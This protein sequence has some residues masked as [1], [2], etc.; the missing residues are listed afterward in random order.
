MLFIIIIIALDVC[1]HVKFRCP[2]Q[3]GMQ[4]CLT[5][6][7]IVTVD[8]MLVQLIPFHFVG[9]HDYIANLHPVYSARY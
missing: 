1:G 7:G 5:A 8:W 9:W 4:R 2:V 6:H 3:I